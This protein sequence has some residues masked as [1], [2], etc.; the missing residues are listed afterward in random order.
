MYHQLSLDK[1]CEDISKKHK[2]EYNLSDVL[3]M[4]ISTRIIAP[5]SK[6]SSYD[7]AFNF[8]EQPS[9][10]L[11]HVY[12]SLDI[13][14]KHSDEIQSLVYANSDNL[15]DRNKEVLYY[16]CTN[17]FFEIEQ[18]RG[19]AQ[20]GKSK[21]HRPNP[22]VQMGLF[23]DGN[24]LPLCFSIFDG[25]KNEQPSLKPLEKKILK[26]FGLSKFIVC[27]DAGLGSYENRKFNSKLERSFIVTQSLKTVK[28]H[29]QKWA[30]D[31]NGWKISGSKKTYNIDNINGKEFEETIFFKERWINEKG[32]EQRL[33]V[34]YSI[35]QR[36]YQQYIRQKQIDRAKKII[37]TPS[38]LK[39]RNQ[40]SPK[41]FIDETS[42]TNDGEI[43]DK[44]IL[45]LNEEKI[46]KEEKFD[47]F[48]AICTNLE[49][50][51]NEIIHINKMRWQIESCFRI[52]KSEFKTRPVYLRNEDGYVNNFVYQS[53]TD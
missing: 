37:Y 41:R 2:I 27:T 3:N 40:N 5:S 33:I 25:N 18:P 46:R 8:L 47:G 31:P 1:I 24:G 15:I 13:L 48:Y 32:L 21:E 28:D 44:K 42:V 22:I 12:R 38:K 11:Q 49:K 17:Y 16:D 50:D 6:L 51:I 7:Y 14:S 34:S 19:C 26:D 39:E 52:M 43:C 45:N 36:N 35:K 29:I 4:L 30:L 20:Y 53:I 10:E 23:L 9:F